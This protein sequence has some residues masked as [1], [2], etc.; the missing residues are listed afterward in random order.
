MSTRRITAL[1]FAVLVIAVIGALIVHYDTRPIGR[2]RGSD[3]REIRAAVVGF[4]VPWNS[5]TWA[6]RSSW[7]TLIRKRLKF[8]V[9]DLRPSSIATSTVYPDGT[10][11][12]NAPLVTV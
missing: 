8:R 4:Y 1:S 5:F 6:N 12:E 2:L 3:V 10:R 9:T 11:V 7:P